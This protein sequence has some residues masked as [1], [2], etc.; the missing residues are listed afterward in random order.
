M[1]IHRNYPCNAGNYQRGRDLPVSFLVLHYVGAEGGAEANAKY[2]GRT[3]GI[4]ASAHYFVDHGPHAEVWASVPEGDTAWH[5]GRS[6]GMYKHPQC[7]NANSIGIE[8]C[9]HKR[10]DGSWYIDPETVDRAVELSQDIMER[11]HIPVDHVLRHFDVTGKFC[12]QPWVED[13]RAWETFKARLEESEMTREEVQ[14]MV[15]EAVNKALAERDEVMARSMQTL[16]TWAAPSWE[17]AVKAGVLDGTR[18]GGY[19]TREQHAVT[20]DRL[21]LIKEDP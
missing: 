11:Y 14:A 17:K 6:D 10:Q 18:P 19:L 21:G 16:S 7:R 8:M 5:C 15:N 13:P 12:P 1:E 2:Y 4:K 3:P 9:C 20:L